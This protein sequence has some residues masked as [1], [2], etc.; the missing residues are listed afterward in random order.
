MSI[1]D[2]SK[3]MLT[4]KATTS[5]IVAFDINAGKC[6]NTQQPTSQKMNN[7]RNMEAAKAEILPTILNSW[8]LLCFSS[9]CSHDS[10]YVYLF[11]I[12]LLER[13][14]VTESA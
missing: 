6:T 12:I 8:L 14:E 3:L 11:L 5:C 10:Q 4:N 13:V 9:K 7:G 1:T 2:F